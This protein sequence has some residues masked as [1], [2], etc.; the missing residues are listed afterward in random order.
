MLERGLTAKTVRNVITFVHSVFALA[1]ENGW[2]RSNPV[3]RATRPR[4]RRAGDADP[5]LAI[6]NAA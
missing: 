5:D 4:R 6:P 3:L 2:V 1:M